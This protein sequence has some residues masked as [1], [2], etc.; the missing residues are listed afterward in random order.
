MMTRKKIRPRTARTPSFQLITSQ[1]MFSVTAMATRQAPRTMK[2]M[3]ER[4]R[5]EIIEI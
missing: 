4:R 1:P 5:P 3:T 2:K